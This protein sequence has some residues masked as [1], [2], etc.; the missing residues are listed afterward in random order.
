MLNFLNTT[1]QTVAWLKQVHDAGDLVIKP[2]YQRNPVWTEN[3]KSYLIDS[4]LH[5]FP[6]PELYMQVEVDE[7]GR[8]THI[9]VDGQQR[10]RACIEFLEGGYAMNPDDSPTWGDMRFDDLAPEDKR[11]I[12][13]Y[14]LVVRLLPVVPEATLRQIFRRLNRNVVALNA[15]E[16]RHATYWGAFIT[17]MEKLA[18]LP[19]WEGTG[20]FTPKNIRR[21]LDVEFVSELAVAFLHGLQNKKTNLERMY[22][23]Y[24][25]EFEQSPRVEEAFSKTLGE[26]EQ[27][28]PN[29]RQTR[30]RKK[31]D[32]YTLFLVFRDIQRVFR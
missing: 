25:K 1:H 29:I 30:W 28:L 4:I 12:Y 14:Q 6:V 17:L 10:V 15:Q 11:K 2:P 31:S 19:Y 8:E 5:G 13:G 16:L 3:Q 9:V 20:V 26:L 27:A 7:H 22:Q 32:F 21:M 18:D 24:E 23:V